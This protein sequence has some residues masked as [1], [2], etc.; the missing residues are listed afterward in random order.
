MHRLPRSALGK[1]TPSDG[2]GVVR[3]LPP[4]RRRRQSRPQKQTARPA[5]W[6]RCP[7][8]RDRRLR[9]RRKQRP[10]ARASGPAGTAR[11][12][13]GRQ[14]WNPRLG[15]QPYRGLRKRPGQRR[16]ELCTARPTSRVSRRTPR[17]RGQVRW[18]APCDKPQAR[19]D[20]P[21]RRRRGQTHARLGQRPRRP[22]RQAYPPGLSGA[23]GRPPRVPAQ[24]GSRGPRQCARQQLGCAAPPRAGAHR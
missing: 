23:R 1:A 8:S 24:G 13:R 7:R 2:D 11:G 22:E 18:A 19:C 16:Q 6:H 12:S 15:L 20:E 5:R 21:R 14:R 17:R 10:G 3:G 4:R 9:L